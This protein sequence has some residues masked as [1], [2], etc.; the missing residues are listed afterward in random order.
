MRLRVMGGPLAWS[1]FELNQPSCLGALTPRP[2]VENA[3]DPKKRAQPIDEGR[4]ALQIGC[5]RF[6]WMAISSDFAKAAGSLSSRR[7]PIFA[8]RARQ[9]NQT[10][11]FR[12]VPR[13]TCPYATPRL[14]EIH[15]IDRDGVPWAPKHARSRRRAAVLFARHTQKCARRC[16]ST[17]R[18]YTRFVARWKAEL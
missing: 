18:H 8:H 5:G 7:L 4:L 17:T 13:S 3:G 15:H 1:P 9:T 12:L 10:R 2:Q 6:F 16:C 14:D 11:T